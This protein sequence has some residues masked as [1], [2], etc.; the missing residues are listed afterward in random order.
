M[1]IIAVKAQEGA[2]PGARR[3]KCALLVERAILTGAALPD[4]EMGFLHHRR[5]FWPEFRRL[6]S[7]AYGYQEARRGRFRPSPRDIS[8]FL[9]VYDWLCWLRAQPDGER[10]LKIIT[11]YAFGASFG[12]LAAR[13][14]RSDERVRQWHRAAL[15]AICGRFGKE[16]DQM[17]AG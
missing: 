13:F 8:N 16:I 6:A 11:A 12:K 15:A 9:P 17:E 1:K 4:R 10:D 14:G 2:A 5:S 3:A 7:E